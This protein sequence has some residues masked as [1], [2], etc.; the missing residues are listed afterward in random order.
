MHAGYTAETVTIV[1]SLGVF[2]V[3]A[4]AIYMITVITLF[5]FVA[6]IT[7]YLITVYTHIHFIIRLFVYNT[8]IS[9]RESTY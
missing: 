2:L 9:I 5:P 7:D 6:F 8:L 4:G 3:A 1:A